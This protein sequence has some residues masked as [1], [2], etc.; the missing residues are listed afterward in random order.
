MS[1]QYSEQLSLCQSICETTKAHVLT[2]ED[3]IPP[4]QLPYF[5]MGEKPNYIQKFGESAISLYLQHIACLKHIRNEAIE[6]TK[7]TSY[8]QFTFESSLPYLSQES[9]PNFEIPVIMS[10]AHYGVGACHE[11]ALSIWMK[12]LEQK[13]PANL[14]K[15][16]NDRTNYGHAVVLVGNKK[17]SICDNILSLNK[18][19]DEV[20]LVDALIGYVGPANKYLSSQRQYLKHFDFKYIEDVLTLSNNEF[21]F[22]KKL[23]DELIKRLDSKPLGQFVFESNVSHETASLEKLNRLSRLRFLGHVDDKIQVN[24]FCKI[25]DIA[26]FQAAIALIAQLQAGMF[27]T[28][29]CNTYLI[30][31]GINMPSEIPNTLSL[32]QRIQLT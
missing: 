25:Q 13:T 31:P 27:I 8:H 23:S 6:I 15:F 20:L 1:K 3:I 9:I 5:L 14:I 12:L 32:A 26:D 17:P 18:Y 4:Q 10:V 19:D 7:D 30:F 16:R 2:S 11:L 29:K 28:F 21:L 24:A 22:Y